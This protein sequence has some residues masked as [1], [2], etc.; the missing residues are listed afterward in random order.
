MNAAP[1]SPS[2]RGDGPSDRPTTV[3]WR[4]LALLLAFSFMSW[5][6]RVSMSVA[7]D[8]A[9]MKDYGIS[10]T[11]MGVV[12]S[13]LLFAYALFMTPGGW[14]IDRFGAWRALVLMGFGSALF[15]ALT[16]LVGWALLT[17]GVLWVALIGIRGLMGFFTAPIY[18]ASGQ[19]IRRWLPF[20]QRAGAN[21]LVMAAAL[22]G[23][24]STFELFGGLIDWFGW[25]TAFLITGGVTA[26]ITLVWTV[27]AT[28]HP[29]LHPSTNRAELALIRGEEVPDAVPDELLEAVGKGWG[30]RDTDSPAPEKEGKKSRPDWLVLLGNRSLVLLTIS[31]AAIGYFEYLFYFWIHHYFKKELKLEE[32]ARLYATIVNLAMAVGMFLGGWLADRLVRAYGYR[33]GRTIVPVSGMLASAVLLLLG[34]L[35]TEPFWIVLWLSLSLAAAG[36][37]E[38]PFWATAIELGG[39]KGGTSA[40]IFNTGGNVGGNLAPFVTPAVGQWLGWEWG[41]GLG[42]VVCLAGVTLWIWIDPAR[43]SGEEGV[44]LE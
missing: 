33:K 20:R 4:V 16:G 12:Y 42:S 17:G 18:P 37:T 28:N 29:A 9:I 35:A 22:V 30:G 34:I 23:I 13:A 41:I 19:V 36:A 27:Y 26:L 3:R 43:R 7:G 1:P 44:E 2:P 6:N 25:Q 39:R 11:R 21:G 31:Y 40:G 32:E 10:E 5:F 38:G 14:F 8:E 15:G 24:A